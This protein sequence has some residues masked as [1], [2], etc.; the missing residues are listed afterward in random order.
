MLRM[1]RLQFARAKWIAWLVR[2]NLHIR[3]AKDITIDFVNDDQTVT[4]LGRCIRCGATF[5]HVEK[6]S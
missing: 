1:V 5:S 3:D 2:H 6:K 4:T